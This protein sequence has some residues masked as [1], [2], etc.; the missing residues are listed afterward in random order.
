[1]RVRT[2][3]QSPHPSVYFSCLSLKWLQGPGLKVVMP[4]PVADRK[5]AEDSVIQGH[6]K[7]ASTYL[8]QRAVVKMWTPKIKDQGQDS[9]TGG[10]PG[11]P[12]ADILGVK[13]E[14]GHL[15]KAAACELEK[16]TPSR[17]KNYKHALWVDKSGKGCLCRQSS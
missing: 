15:Q 8:P 6:L 2:Q 17:W 3:G 11:H 7:E 1:M 10:S 12:L 9:H 5:G 4:L 16:G 14:C 13:R